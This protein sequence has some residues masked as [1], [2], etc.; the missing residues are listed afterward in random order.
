MLE[1]GARWCE[2][3]LPEPRLTTTSE[4]NGSRATAPTHYCRR[5]EHDTPLLMAK[6]YG[7]KPPRASRDG[8]QT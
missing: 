7:F 1:L 8:R 5:R 2:R 4:R 3:L 6:A